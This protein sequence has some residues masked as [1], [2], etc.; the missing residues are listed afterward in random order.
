MKDK[1]YHQ[2][3]TNLT[4]C[5]IVLRSVDEN[6]EVHE[7]FIGFY[8]CE[9]TNADTMLKLIIDRLNEDVINKHP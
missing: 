7:D 4:Q 5:A 1:F 8:V 2:D 3:L 9:R 6:F